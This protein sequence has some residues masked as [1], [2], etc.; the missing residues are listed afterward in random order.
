MKECFAS[1]CDFRP[2][3]SGRFF[4]GVII[5]SKHNQLTTRQK[6]QQLTVAAVF[7]A[8]SFI[9]MLLFRIPL[10]TPFYELEFSDFPLL[11]CAFV[12][13][14][15]YSIAA[16][17]IVSILQMLTVS[18]FSGIIG[19]VM[20]FVSSAAMILLVYFVKKR[21]NGLKGVII[22]AIAGI[23]V[24]TAVMIPMNIWLASEFMQLP[25]KKFVSGYIGVCIAFNVIKSLCNIALFNILYPVI[26]KQY[27]KLLNKK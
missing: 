24:M 21:I 1:F 25:A 16:L 15:M 10:F 22:S 27:N 12:V 17:F 6:I 4:Y 9:L 3:F 8:I 2:V 7:T 14:P 5:L 13:S 23:L 18:S 20:H 19:F 26:L 11:L